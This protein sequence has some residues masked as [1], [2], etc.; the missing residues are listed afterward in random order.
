MKG[1]KLEVVLLWWGKSVI[2]IADGS[3]FSNIMERLLK[4]SLDYNITMYLILPESTEYVLL[5]NIIFDDSKTVSEYLLNPVDK[6]DSRDWITYEKM[7]EEVIIEESSKI[8]WIDNYERERDLETYKTESFIDTYRAIL[9]KIDGIKSSYTIK[10]SL[11]KIKD[12][13]LIIGDLHGSKIDK[14]NKDNEK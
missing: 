8:D 3:N 9:N 5:H 6:Y 11:Y 7:Y 1:I 2:I 4:R 10:Y 14:L 12:G 13:E